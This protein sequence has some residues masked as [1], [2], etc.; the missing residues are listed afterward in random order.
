[1]PGKKDTLSPNTT[2]RM[3]RRR[4][5]PVDEIVDDVVDEITDDISR[6]PVREMMDEAVG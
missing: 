4:R 1:M 2:T 6:R 5:K 3:S